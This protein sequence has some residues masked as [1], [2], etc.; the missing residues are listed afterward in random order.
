MSATAMAEGP[1]PEPL[2]GR[3]STAV[4]AVLLGLGVLDA[5]GYSLIAPV[6]PELAQHTEASVT[7][8]GMLVAT[9]PLGMVA[10]FALGGAAVRRQAPASVIMVSLAL[11][12]MGSLGFV[13]GSDLAVF[14][15]ARL[16]MGLGSGCLWLGITF[17]TL[18]SWPGQE[19]L[20]M[21]RV[22]AAYSAGGLLGPLL[23]SIHGVRDPFAVYLVLTL[24]MAVPVLALQLPAHGATFTADRRALRSR[25]FWAASA[26]IAFAVMALGTLEGVLPLHFGTKLAQAQIGALYAATSVLVAVAA[27]LAA[28]LSPR[29]ALLA[30]TA[31]V[32]AGLAAAGASSSVPVWIVSLAVA[33]C[34]IGLANTG[35]IG[36][37]LDAVPAQRIVTA[38]VLWSQIGILGYLLAPLT[39]GPVADAYGYTAVA[40]AVSVGGVTVAITLAWQQRGTQSSAASD[41]P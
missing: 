9:F 39:G 25:G 15:P 33:G 37:L 38:M 11:V 41:T 4:Y 27:A 32:I 5:A 12:A 20:C 21:S 13:F 30:S 26:G 17:T 16:V 2:A 35:A 28:R 18:A 22:F 31:L 36:V 14:A 23:G 10:G 40:A 1:T 3:R 19:Y 29:R 8:M 6:L 24:L 34:G 7:V